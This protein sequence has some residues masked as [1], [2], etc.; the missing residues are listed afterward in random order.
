MTTMLVA[1]VFV[2]GQADAV[3]TGDA[4]LT[5]NLGGTRLK[6]FTY[7]PKSFDQGP[8]LLVFHGTDR[9]AVDYRNDA[10]GMARRFGALV[11]A[12]EFDRERFPNARYNRGGLLHDDGTAA[13]RSEWTWSLI[14]K[15]AERFRTREGRP[16]MPYYLI[17]H[18][19]GGQFV[20]RL[21][22]FVPTG[23][24]G[25]V[26]ANAGVHLFPTR[27]L[28]FSFGF[29]DLPEP[30][31]NDA[32]LRHYLAQPITIYL[33]TDDTVRDDDFY[34][35]DVADRQGRNRLKRGRNVFQAARTLAKKKGW[36]FGWRL[37]E[38]VGVGHD[39]QAM[40]DNPQCA[41]ALF[42]DRTVPVKVR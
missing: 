14:P 28:P 12:P 35:D 6:V 40:F 17:G 18:S 16:D 10:R 36:P 8:M 38:A 27:D 15:L 4:T 26:V 37:V 25:A 3:P 7:K 23:A 20:E 24:S 30:I 31:S 19:A 9:N 39:H 29:G 2:L 33:G 22:A 21:A 1:A 11:V 32:Q 34:T 13:P 41:V 42:G 5:V